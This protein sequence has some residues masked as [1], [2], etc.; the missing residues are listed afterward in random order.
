MDTVTT[1]TGPD[2]Q[3]IG[4]YLRGLVQVM[5]A[6]HVLDAAQRERVLTFAVRHGYDA[7][8]VDA[9]VSSVLDNEH[10]PTTVPRFNRRATAEHFLREA[11]AMALCDGALHA[12]EREW[13][14][15]AARCNDVDEAVVLDALKSEARPPSEIVVE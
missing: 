5:A 12:R 10:F 9:V 6:D 3:D 7:A 4:L 2:L 15:E 11:A 1:P 14:V 13:L 8:W